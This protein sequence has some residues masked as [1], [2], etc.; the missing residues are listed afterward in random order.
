MA[1]SREILMNHHSGLQFWKDIVRLTDESGS[2][3]VRS[4]RAALFIWMQMDKPN[5]LRRQA[6]QLFSAARTCLPLS[7]VPIPL[8]QRGRLVFCFAHR[9]PANM[10]NLLPV[11]READRRGLL[12][13]IVSAGDFSAE[14]KEFSGRV[15]IVTAQSLVGLISGRERQRIMAEA[16]RTLN[17]VA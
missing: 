8:A 5:L 13:G 11:A 10:N 16:F 17:R 6:R 15:P 12:G 7:A 3:S 1:T 9:S 4:L 14:L 2:D